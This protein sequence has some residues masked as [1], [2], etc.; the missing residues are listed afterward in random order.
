MGRELIKGEASR[1]LSRFLYFGKEG[2]LRGRE[3]GDQIQTEKFHEILH[4]ADLVGTEGLD[5]FA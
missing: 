4:L 1:D 5:F 3:F 2:V